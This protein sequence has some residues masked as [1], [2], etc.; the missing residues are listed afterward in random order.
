MYLCFTG[1][2]YDVCAICLDEYEEG[3]KLRVLP[4]SHGKRVSVDVVWSNLS[5]VEKVGST[6]S[7]QGLVPLVAGCS[8]IFL[9]PITTCFIDRIALILFLF[10]HLN[11]FH[12]VS[13][14]VACY[15]PSKIPETQAKCSYFFTELLDTIVSFYYIF[16]SFQV[17]KQFTILIY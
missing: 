8:T 5:T 15:T 9:T 11:T 12:V 1:D 16:Q 10:P 6:T 17:H 14:S 7:C 2:V 4:C 13:F 3:E